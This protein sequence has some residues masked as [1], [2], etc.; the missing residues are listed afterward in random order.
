MEVREASK[1]FKDL[2]V[3]QKAHAAVLDIYRLTKGF[4]KDEIYVL[5]S[6]IRRSSI[7][8]AANI[9]EGFK[10]KSAPDK[11]RFF[12]IAQG[13]LSETEYYLILAGDLGYAATNQLLIKTNEVGRLMEK[14][15][16]AIKRV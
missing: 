1:S 6:Q 15:M 3:W 2:V 14:Y 8:V 13:S 9:A 5:T 10:K 11:L 16:Q 7:S 12:N 4:P